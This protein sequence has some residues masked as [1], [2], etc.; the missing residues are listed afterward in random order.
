MEATEAEGFGQLRPV[1]PL[2]ALHL[3][4]FGDKLPAP[5]NQVGP[6]RRLL[7]LQTKAGLPCRAVLTRKYATNR[8]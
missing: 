5:T 1:R 7:R 8:P 2:A 6:H 3:D 4:H